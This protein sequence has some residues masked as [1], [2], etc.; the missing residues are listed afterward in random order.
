MCMFHEALQFSRPRWTWHAPSNRSASE[1]IWRA[2]PSVHAQHS[3]VQPPTKGGSSTVPPS[4]RTCPVKAEAFAANAKLSLNPQLTHVSGRTLPTSQTS[5]CER[6]SAV[7]VSLHVR[8]GR[9][10]HVATGK[11][12]NVISLRDKRHNAVQLATKMENTPWGHCYPH[13]LNRKR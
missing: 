1:E 6:R 7:T 4:V 11:K 12:S 2:A 9:T 13:N 8:T 3:A 10:W 5:Y